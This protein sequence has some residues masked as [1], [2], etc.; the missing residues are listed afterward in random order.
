MSCKLQR[1]KIQNKIGGSFIK[2]R[3]GEIAGLFM[4]ARMP[5]STSRQSR[6]T[7]LKKSS[8]VSLYGPPVRQVTSSYVLC[9]TNQTTVCPLNAKGQKRKC[10]VLWHF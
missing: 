8:T 5:L 1:F 7:V 3:Y 2:L 6:S 10:H 9:V 4:T